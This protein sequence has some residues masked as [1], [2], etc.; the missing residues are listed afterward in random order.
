MI[1][2]GG[3]G[4]ASSQDEAILEVLKASIKDQVIGQNPNQG[5]LEILL[6][7]QQDLGTTKHELR[8]MLVSKSMDVKKV[9][10]LLTTIEN[11]LDG[12]YSRLQDELIA[13]KE[14]V[15]SLNEEFISGIF[16]SVLKD[17]INGRESKYKKYFDQNFEKV[18]RIEKIIKENL[19]PQQ[20]NFIEQPR[21]EKVSTETQTESILDKEIL[22]LDISLSQPQNLPL[23][24]AVR[25]ELQGAGQDFSLVKK[26]DD[27]QDPMQA[28]LEQYRESGFEINQQ[29]KELIL[30]YKF[31]KTQVTNELKRLQDLK[32]KE[33]QKVQSIISGNLPNH[34]IGGA[35]DLDSKM[36]QIFKLK[37]Y[38]KIHLFK[39]CTQSIS[40]LDANAQPSFTFGSAQ[41]IQ[42]ILKS[43]C[44]IIY[45]FI[46]PH[47]PS[48]IY[49]MKQQSKEQQYDSLIATIDLARRTPELT[50]YDQLRSH[51]EN[52]RILLTANIVPQQID[53]KPSSTS[54]GSG[55]EVKG[56][57]IANNNAEEHHK[58]AFNQIHSQSGVIPQHRQ[59]V[60][61]FSLG[62]QERFFIL[63]VA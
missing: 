48:V 2:Q 53:G 37:L 38:D 59:I 56:A 4:Q 15:D 18:D 62:P 55:S 51:F 16:K 34:L 58:Q 23:E 21:P 33:E 11:G 12:M 40:Q 45:Y 3:A 24:K 22:Q 30:K 43:N 32:A 6:K 41:A 20:A 57:T 28:E 63:I 19:T 25:V 9:Q 35:S 60:Q 27:S 36:R 50:K 29:L 54:M 31:D 46:E 42:T 14:K 61:D 8:A 49:L 13:I 26:L 1:K 17:E 44:V 10:E 47:T 5:T 7:V 52:D 39:D